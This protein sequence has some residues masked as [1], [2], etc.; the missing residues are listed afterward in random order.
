MMGDFEGV[1][2]PG[3]RAAKLAG[4]SRQRLY[5]WEK[6][7][8]ITPSYRRR[9]SAHS[10]VRLYDVQRLTELKVAAQLVSH[11]ATVRGMRPLLAFLRERYEAPLAS[12]K[13]GVQRGRVYY[14]DGTGWQDGANPGQF[15][16]EGVLRLNPIKASMRRALR[17]ERTEEQVGRVVKRRSVQGSAPIFEGTRIPLAAVWEFLEDGEPISEILEAY[18][19]LRDADVRKAEQ[20]REAARLLKAGR[21]LD[22]LRR[23]YDFSEDEV[24]SIKQLAHAA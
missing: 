14:N 7:E 2:V 19:D 16:F 21:H 24:R 10:V 9:L 12:L 15:A 8:L 4:I 11:G 20:M 13:Y 1:M 6:T 3:D 18:P 23:R 17:Y 5:Y 22:E